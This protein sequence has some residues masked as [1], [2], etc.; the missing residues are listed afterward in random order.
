MIV[1]IVALVAALGGGAYAAKK[2]GTKQLANKSVNTKKLAK[3]ER[4]QGYLATQ[5]ASIEMPASVD[6]TV[7]ALRLPRGS[8]QVVAG[9]SLGGKA[10][11]LNF[12]NCRLLDDGVALAVADGSTDVAAF[13]DTVALTAFSDGGAVTVVC[14]PSSAA[15]ARGRTI[16]ATRVARVITP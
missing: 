2:I 1:A 5:P 15:A 13:A 16:T 12:I 9:V 4:S 6:T 14:N 7:A 11:G 10:A 3:A 8:F